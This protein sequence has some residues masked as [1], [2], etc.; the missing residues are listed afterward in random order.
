MVE[1]VSAGAVSDVSPGGAL[2]S[3]CTFAGRGAHAFAGWASFPRPRCSRFGGDRRRWPRRSFGPATENAFEKSSWHR[4]CNRHRRNLAARRA[5]PRCAWRGSAAGAFRGRLGARRAW[6]LILLRETVVRANEG[7]EAKDEE[8]RFEHERR[9]GDGL[10]VRASG[11]S[12]SLETF[13]TGGIDPTCGSGH[14][15]LAGFRARHSFVIRHSDFV[16]PIGAKAVQRP[17]RLGVR[18]APPTALPKACTMSVHS[19]SPASTVS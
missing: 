12:A 4:R 18:H 10:Y 14:F 3:S 11:T 15:L 17:A 16:I 6:R 13:E 1:E 19:H 8:R 9:G 5:A 2:R 7:K